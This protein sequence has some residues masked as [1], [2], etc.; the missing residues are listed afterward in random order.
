MTLRRKSTW[1][2]APRVP[3]VPLQRVP[4]YARSGEVVSVPKE[5][6][7]RSRP[8]R[9]WVAT[10]PCD[11]CG[12]PETQCAHENLGKALQGKVC[13]SKTFSACIAH[14]SHIG[15]HTMFDLYID[16]SRDEARELGARLSAQM[17]ERARVAGWR[18]SPEGITRA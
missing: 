8:Y 12:W 14:G 9:M 18:F 2:P 13:D 3:A 15:H 7:L 6:I 11:L 17:R 10:W 4:N 1:T 5:I 16:I